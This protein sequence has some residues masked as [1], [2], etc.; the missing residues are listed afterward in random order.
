MAQGEWLL[1][2]GSVVNRCVGLPAQTALAKLPCCQCPKPAAVHAGVLGHL[3]RQG[4]HIRRDGQGAAQLSACCRSGVHTR[5]A[6]CQA[7][8]RAGVWPVAFASGMQPAT[9]RV[10]FTAPCVVAACC[11]KAFA[12]AAQQRDQQPTRVL[13]SAALAVAAACCAG[14]APQPLRAG[15]AVPPRGDQ[16]PRARRL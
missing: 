4:Q 13:A 2:C 16:H 3:A 9:M 8:S 15:G 7:E 10:A 14:P 6:K 5:E 1:E 12:V 11:R